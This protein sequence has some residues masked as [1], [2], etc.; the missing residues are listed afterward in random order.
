MSIKSLLLEAFSNTCQN[1]GLQNGFEDLRIPF[2]GHKMAIGLAT[3]VN[4]CSF[5]KIKEGV[6][7]RVKI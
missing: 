2:H 3:S 4:K 1:E 7:K 6:N 5:R